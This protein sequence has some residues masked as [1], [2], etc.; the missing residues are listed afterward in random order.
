M[1]Q[2]SET[3]LAK[4]PELP[5][6][7]SVVNSTTSWMSVS[8]ADEPPSEI[9]PAQTYRSTGE[10]HTHQQAWLQLVRTQ[11]KHE[12]TQNDVY[13]LCL[14]L[15]FFLSHFPLFYVFCPLHWGLVMS[16]PLITELW[17]S[18]LIN[19]LFLLLVVT[20]THLH[21]ST[22]KWELSIHETSIHQVGDNWRLGDIHACTYTH[23]ADWKDK[24]PAAHMST[25]V[26]IPF[27]SSCSE[28]LS[29]VSVFILLP[30]KV[31]TAF[32]GPSASRGFPFKYTIIYTLIHL[33]TS[34][35]LTH[36]VHM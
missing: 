2:T 12:N 33:Q 35:L 23:I 15:F 30:V 9:Q 4:F 14:S 36:A 16:D 8:F 13:L 24:H 25:H 22:C 34:F 19:S 27:H 7:K 17:L 3:A 32:S 31:E 21:I 5:Q 18:S 28:A 26:F 1:L 29:A 20:Y 6:A 10:I 11:D